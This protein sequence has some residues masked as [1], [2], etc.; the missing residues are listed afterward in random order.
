[1]GMDLAK[2]PLITAG[3]L[4]RLFGVGANTVNAM[5]ERLGI[6][7]TRLANGR[8]YMSFDQAQRINDEMTKRMRK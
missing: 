7:A 3:A 2:E 5:V 1:M 6:K 4:A 8:I